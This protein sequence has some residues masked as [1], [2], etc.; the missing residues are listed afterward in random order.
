[1]LISP[2]TFGSEIKTEKVRTQVSCMY[3]QNTYRIDYQWLILHFLNS[4]KES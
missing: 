4:K 1:M 3:I 2:L